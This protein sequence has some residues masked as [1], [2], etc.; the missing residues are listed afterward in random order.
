M[1]EETINPTIQSVQMALENL[2]DY[3]LENIIS[4][5][6]SYSVMHNALEKDLH[7]DADILRRLLAVCAHDTATLKLTPIVLGMIPL[8]VSKAKLQKYKPSPDMVPSALAIIRII[9]TIASV[10]KVESLLVMCFDALLSY[11]EDTLLGVADHHK[12]LLEMFNLS[13]HMRIQS[14]TR[15][16]ACHFLL[17]FLKI[18]SPAK[19]KQFIVDG[20]SVWFSKIIP[21]AMAHLTVA[22]CETQMTLELLELITDDLE[23][24]DYADNPQWHMVLECVC[25]NKQYP[26][27]MK[28]LL[29]AGNDAWCRLWIIFVRLLKSQIT[30]SFSGIGTPI[31]S[32][33]PVVEIAF[34][35]DVPRRCKAFECWKAL[36]DSFSNEINE[37]NVN[38]RIKLLLIPL[39]SNNAKA[40]ETALA[41]FDC[42]WHL[43]KKFQHKMDLDSVMIYFLNF[44][45]GRHTVVTLIPTAV[46]PGQ[47]SPRM[48]KLCNLAIVDLVGH[49][50]CNG[51]TSLI[52]L[53]G[54]IITTTHLVDN[55]NQWIFSITSVVVKTAKN[56][57]PLTQQQLT[58]LWKSFLMTIGDL[59]DNNIKND[60]FAETLG[61]VFNL[62]QKCDANDQFLEVLFNALILSMFDEDMKISQLLGTAD[63]PNSP[64]LSIVK[65]MLHPSLHGV[66]KNLP[67]SE[68]I[69]KFKS[70]TK[71][72]ITCE[73]CRTNFNILGWFF[74]MPGPANDAVLKFWS[75]L[76]ESVCDAACDLCFPVTISLL[77][78]P[79]KSMPLFTDV[80]IPAMTW[81]N[82]YNI[83]YPRLKRVNVDDKILEA[84]PVSNANNSVVYF[85]L[86]IILAILKHQFEISDNYSP[87]LQ[88]KINYLLN[89]TKSIDNIENFEPIFPLLV[90]RI[91]AIMH[92]VTEKKSDTVTALILICVK[93]VLRTLIQACKKQCNVKEVL[94]LVT[95]LL[96]PLDT[97]FRVESYSQLIPA[98]TVHLLKYS[99]VLQQYPE[100]HDI[101][102][103]LMELILMKTKTS[104][105]NYN[106]IR[107][108]IENWK[109][110]N[111]NLKSNS[112]NIQFT[113]PKVKEVAKK[114]S[115]KGT[116]I[117]NTVVE[118]GEE[119]VVV[120]SNWR[121]NPRRLTENQKE[122]LQRKRED[123]PAL[124][125][126]LSQSQ[127]E[128]K[129]V[130]W[131]TESQ[132]TASSSR[133]ESKSNKPGDNQTDTEI[134]KNLASTDVVP[135]ILGNF[136]NGSSKDPP[137]KD[138]ANKV[139]ATPSPKN[140][141][142]PRMALKDRVF[143]NVRYLIAS[144]SSPKENNNVQD[145]SNKTDNNENTPTN[146][147]NKK[148]PNG[149]SSA[150]PLLSADRPSRVKRKPKKFE[151]LQLQMSKKS[152]HSL[153]NMQADKTQKN[154]TEL[155]A[156]EAK[157]TKEGENDCV[158]SAEDNMNNPTNLDESQ[159]GTSD[160]DISQSEH[161]NNINSDQDNQTNTLKD[162]TTV[163][164]EIN[165]NS[166][167]DI[168]MSENNENNAI[169]TNKI[170][171]LSEK[172][173]GD[174]RDSN[175]MDSE[176][177]SELP[178]SRAS[179]VVSDESTTS[180]VSVSTPKAAKDVSASN[181][182]EDTNG[183]ATPKGLKVPTVIL[184][185]N[186][187][188]TTPVLSKDAK[189]ASISKTSKENKEILTPK[190]SK[191]VNE[192]STPRGAK[193]LKMVST[194]RTSKEGST[195]KLHKNVR[196]V[197]TSKASKDV[198]TPRTSNHDKEVFTSET[199][200]PETDIEVPTP[201]LP[202]HHKEMSDTKDCSGN[203]EVSDN[204]EKTKG[205]LA[206]EG[207]NE[208]ST[209]ETSN[210][211][212][213][214]SSVVQN[215]K[216]LS[217]SN[218]V[219][220]TEI[221]VNKVPEEE[222]DVL[223]PKTSKDEKEISTPKLSKGSK[224]VPS[225][226]TKEV[227]KCTTPKLTKKVETEPQIVSDSS[228]LITPKDV[229]VVLTAT[230]LKQ[231]PT[232]NSPKDLK[233]S[234]PH[235]SKE[236]KV[237]T[238]KL[239]PQDDQSKAQKSTVKKVRKSRI[240]KE[241]A[242]DT[243][244]GHPYL[245]QTGK[246]LTRKSLESANTG[247]RKSLADKLSK[248]KSDGSTVKSEKKGREKVKDG[249]NTN[250][251][252]V[253]VDDSQERD[254]DSKD[255]SSSF[256]D[257]P[258]SDDI[259][260]SSQDSTITTI[261][262]KSTRKTPKKV[263]VVC[264]EK[265]MQPLGKI[266]GLEN[267]QSILDCAIVNI[268]KSPSSEQSGKD[269]SVLPL[270]K[271]VIDDKTQ[272]D[273]TEN[274]DTEPLDAKDVSEDII[275]V[276]D[277]VPAITVASQDSIVG[278]E[279]QEIAEADTQ[280]TDPRDF[281]DIDI[282]QDVISQAS[283][284]SAKAAG[285]VIPETCNTD[286]KVENTPE[287]ST[288]EQQIE[289]CSGVDV[290]NTENNIT[291]TLS[292]SVCVEM[293]Q[294]SGLS[295]PF[296]DAAQ[297]Q[298]DFLNNTVEI[299]PI[300]SMSPDIQKS[301]PTP[302]TSSDYV[303]IKLTS[304]VHSNGEPFEKG[305]SP[306]VFSEDKVSPDK[307]DQSP[308]RVE[309]S[310]SNSSPS[311]SLSLKKNRPQVRS[312]GR[313][314]QMLGLCVPDK[315][316]A[317]VNPEVNES[318]DSKQGSTNTPARK[319][320]RI[321]YNSVHD[322]AENIV[323][324]SGKHDDDE[325]DNFLQ[326][327][328][329]LPAMDSSPSAPIL[330]RK[331][332]EITDDATISPASKRKRVS[333]TDP[334]V[335]QTKSVFKYIEP[336]VLRSPQHAQKRLERQM[337]HAALKSPK[338]LEHAFKLDTVLTK[339]VESFS[340]S[341]VSPLPDDTQQISLDETPVVEV[342]RADELNDVDPICPELLD[343]TDPIVN[344][345]GELSS[346]A[347]KSLLIKELEGKITTIGDLAKMTE[348]EVNRLCIK[349]PKLKVVRKVLSEY[350]LRRNLMYEPLI[351]VDEANFDMTRCGETESVKGVHIEVQT[352]V[353]ECM[354]MEVQT[355]H[356]RTNFT[357]VQTET[358]PIVHT[359]I[360]TDESA[361]ET[362]TDIAKEKLPEKLDYVEQPSVNL[363]KSSVLQL[364]EKLSLNAVTDLLLKK[365]TPSDAKHIFKRI[366]EESVSSDDRSRHV[367]LIKDYCCDTFDAKDL[368]LLCSQILSVVHE[369]P[370]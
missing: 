183:V 134:L 231:L 165:T 243:V 275:L 253:I 261:S 122:K 319:N 61:I 156:H 364:S 220:E 51:C 196:E 3:S 256:E 91:V 287:Q 182:H 192:V 100:T 124:Y 369:K 290:N 146:N 201:T 123:I 30:Q 130:S 366:L 185:K 209:P 223:S 184:T 102:V 205:L 320:L 296:K 283:D 117:V 53:D 169:S 181:G 36:I 362:T 288:P 160:M 249:A 171:I 142:S 300:K 313:A 150:P 158:L 277:D 70:V 9:K 257:L 108:L 145:D 244:E 240:E 214:V 54:K 109:S 47:I 193:I 149:V 294:S 248:V 143:K 289:S 57:N 151:D 278:P 39:K 347:M 293:E 291:A 17:K 353:N 66:Y 228:T 135:T 250:S 292:D 64:I 138:I 44:C 7:I 334:P 222:T 168:V 167:A 295:S 234:S 206:P 307:R 180:K 8:I 271:T 236:K 239:S 200:S 238:P 280:P 258:F 279:T 176:N 356:I 191:H 12:E 225:V 177:S 218:T 38:K 254:S 304:P 247:R 14:P 164:C 92:I 13:C 93:N 4:R 346:P 107:Q 355:E 202:N 59:P 159:D 68:L 235:H 162:G 98:M 141:K 260:E 343:C 351:T 16:Q 131:Q 120:K 31:N 62:V 104:D 316:Q 265:L 55:W 137:P 330:K 94:S 15:L 67:T 211:E 237:T 40:E 273:L 285:S 140:T 224:G 10:S 232:L 361:S 281:M 367:S 112:E 348:L 105:S 352:D 74:D 332:S 161:I 175:S 83:M 115:K 255:Q 25:N 22:G 45:Y 58:C 11:P 103:S 327:Q 81:Y 357:S 328:R 29:Q 317:I 215:E 359:S 204:S 298:Q 35:L 341:E 46:I 174:Q 26:A 63:N 207:T 24:I 227:K 42:W 358:V 34:K 194:P 126:D 212:K 77:M 269:D 306:E 52:P 72:I 203:K 33:L 21:I 350:A 335:F 267:S 365:M 199:H 133:S 148:L 208:L 302:E 322:N 179:K 114:S 303:V 337:R 80:Q 152:R 86:C 69:P 2:E 28:S 310:V 217:P 219:T 110:K 23:E 311:S 321:L 89:L 166:D 198:S 190:A 299:S 354:D 233:E 349:A 85:K 73:S 121:F 111:D 230:D 312:G 50:N 270:N 32:M 314:A 252:S 76:A 79:L 216:E 323:S 106:K 331:L 5:T 186:V 88:Q 213:S 195:S 75:A 188:V 333:F 251:T 363:E 336:G 284:T 144:A 221:A 187:E 173:K 297:R 308:P 246:R 60:L 119:Y 27:M 326:L 178:T 368:I 301:S 189:D 305:A 264:V 18:L 96:K 157:T 41:K 113:T 139:E 82:T 20:T 345:A 170:N 286:Q 153:H 154:D 266:S 329:P 1:P 242:I 49:V 272:D 125:Q 136:F 318:E 43:L 282:T 48:I 241:L 226:K 276:S 97:L 245:K 325:N 101:I 116:S 155:N 344:I 338:R 370:A 197:A 342:I 19:K 339:T 132:D 229:R 71:L 118:N 127:D 56:D 99:E 360:Q 210:V 37:T 163:T 259:I 128:F 87:A 6:Q 129:L 340:E 324:T 78:W 268:P 315:V 262:V 95:N 84:L 147:K 90:D 263:P 172:P 274:M 65:T 309:V